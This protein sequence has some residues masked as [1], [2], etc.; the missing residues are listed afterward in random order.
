VNHGTLGDFVVTVCS[1][2]TAMRPE[3]LQRSKKVGSRRELGH[4]AFLVTCHKLLAADI[5]TLR[6]VTAS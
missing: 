3:V 6:R 5:A 2:I 4:G 1:V